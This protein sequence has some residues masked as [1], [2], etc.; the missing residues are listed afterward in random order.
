M[1]KSRTTVGAMRAVARM[2]R[3]AK[4]GPTRSW[5]RSHRVKAPSSAPDTCDRFDL[6]VGRRQGVLRSLLV[7]QGCVDLSLQ[8]L[9][10]AGIKRSYGPRGRHIEDSLLLLV[11]RRL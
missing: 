11:V 8:N 2:L 1:R 9:R 7:A 5:S 6:Q 3:G 10:D 4:L